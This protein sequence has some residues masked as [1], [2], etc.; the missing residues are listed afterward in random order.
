M[1]V[2]IRRGDIVQRGAKLHLERIVSVTVYFDIIEKLFRAREK[3][4]EHLQS[5]ND[6]RLQFTKARQTITHL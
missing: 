1:T 3:A 2:H 5:L 4:I 6:T